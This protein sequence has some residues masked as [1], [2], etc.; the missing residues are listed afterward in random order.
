MYSAKF[1][2]ETPPTAAIIT[3]A[4]STARIAA[5]PDAPSTLAGKNF[6]P[7]APERAASSAS[8]GENT[9]GSVIMT[10]WCARVSTC[11]S[12]FGDTI[13]WPPTSL[14]RSTSAVV[15]TVPAPIST[16]AGASLT[17]M[18]IERNGSGEFSGISIAVM[19]ASISTPTMASASSG[20]MPRRIATSGRFIA[21]KGTLISTILSFRPDRASRH[22]Q[23]AADGFI[24]IDRL[25]GDRQR[26]ESQPVQHCEPP[27]G[28]QRDSSFRHRAGEP[29]RQFD[30]DQRARQRF[31][32]RGRCAPEQELTRPR[33]EQKIGGEG[34]CL[35]RRLHRSLEARDI[36][37]VF[38]A[39]DR[40]RQNRLARHDAE[41][42]TGH[43]SGEM[44]D[45][46]VLDSYP[47]RMR[48]G[49]AD[50]RF[51]G[52]IKPERAEQLRLLA[53]H[54]VRCFCIALRDTRQ[55]ADVAGFAGHA[56]RLLQN[57]G[58]WR[59]RIDIPGLDP[60]GTRAG[61]AADEDRQMIGRLDCREMRLQHGGKAGLRGH[62]HAF[63]A[64]ALS[65]HL[66]GAVDQPEPEA[67]GAPV[68]RDIGRFGHLNAYPRLTA[69]TPSRDNE[70]GPANL[71]RDIGYCCRK[72]AF[73]RGSGAP[74]AV[75]HRLRR[76]GTPLAK[77]FP[78]TSVNRATRRVNIR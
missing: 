4:G 44:R 1:W 56:R 30:A 17:A 49:H 16:P 14:S 76:G 34:R 25:R 71:P 50:Q 63:I 47:F 51:T 21:G 31:A 3:P 52:G 65:E 41:E 74:F 15:S 18:A 60:A 68:H 61:H 40:K 42:L 75:A 26:V 62:Q 69:E 29:C 2:S 36:L 10:Y 38:G 37:G 66:A 12:T 22:R 77:A 27:R 70:T 19:P 13:S 43:E 11:V 28:N 78:L 23:T 39:R 6:R 57:S 59:G 45:C 54:H 8:V 67:A 32:R 73:F 72:P 58:E 9:P 7:E 46:A 20:L 33:A 48:A 35:V 53:A 24:G 55:D 5:M 64:A